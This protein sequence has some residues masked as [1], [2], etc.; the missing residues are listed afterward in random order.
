MLEPVGFMQV[1][2]RCKTLVSVVRPIPLS[3]Q[4]CYEDSTG[5]TAM[6]PLLDR[7][8]QRLN[9]DLV[10]DQPSAEWYGYTDTVAGARSR[11]VS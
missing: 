4:Y 7:K 2:G 11:Q 5:T 10:E 8:G 9:R 3:W 1:H 6:V